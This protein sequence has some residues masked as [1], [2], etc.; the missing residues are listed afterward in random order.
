MSPA[1]LV[2]TVLIV[3]AAAILL[4]AAARLLKYRGEHAVKCPE[5]QAWAGVHVAALHPHLRLNACSRWPE[6]QDCGQECL[7]HVEAAPAACLVT[8]LL[9]RWY[10]GKACAVCHKHFDEIR[11]S[12]FQPSLLSPDGKIVE[13]S[14]V[15]AEALPSIFS[16]YHPVCWKCSSIAGVVQQHPELVVDR[17]RPA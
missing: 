7:K 17:K 6:R 12:E 5:N 11:W 1:S 4:F 13:W 15:N 10:A 3:V 8:N 16:T 14:A 2:L 9:A